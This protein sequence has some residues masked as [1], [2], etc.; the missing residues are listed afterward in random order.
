MMDFQVSS[1]WIFCRVIDNFGD[2]A[3]ARRLA[4]ILH[5]EHMA[6]VVL[7]IDDL[8]VLS[9][10]DPQI[11][12]NLPAQV[13]G[14]LRIVHW[15]YINN[16]IN[17]LPKPDCVIETF[18]CELPDSVKNI[19]QQNNALWL[20]FE[21]L[22]A[23]K[24]AEEQHLLP[25]LQANGVNKRFYFMGFSHN[26]G[27]LLREKYITNDFSGRFPL[28]SQFSGRLAIYIF[29]YRSPIWHT[30][31]TCWK[32]MN[33]KAN[34]SIAGGQI[35]LPYQK[36][37]LLFQKSQFVPQDEFD[38]LIAQFDVLVVRG[39]DS[40]VRAQYAGKPFF[41]HIY[42]QE[43]QAHLSKLHAFWDKVYKY[44]PADLINAH[45]LL[46]DELNSFH[47]LDENIRQQCWQV[48]LQNFEQW[49]TAMLAW[50]K[51]LL[52]LPSATQEIVNCLSK[53][54]NVKF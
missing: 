13:V 41:W 3:V 11:N 38:D 50:R 43:N 29:A 7:F 18:A 35:F 37:P 14:G 49:Q 15:S 32:N 1:I 16:L 34:V 21:Y 12:V 44:F 53:H 9:H 36:A 2:A 6:H 48:L 5:Q 45:R 54:Q 39:E 40:F 10:L 8:K 31:F 23:E 42:P 25:S 30:W 20:N 4:K 47:K 33:L 46:S 26:S 17:H 22:T 24:W 51:F 19:I 52:T 28:L 27:G